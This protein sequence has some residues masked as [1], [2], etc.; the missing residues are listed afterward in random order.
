M[1]IGNWYPLKRQGEVGSLR[2]AS[3][4]LCLNIKNNEFF[5]K[6]ADF[7]NSGRTIPFPL[8]EFVF[9]SLFE[10][11]NLYATIPLPGEVRA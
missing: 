3:V 10:R 1:D 8:P 7:Q 2:N 5:A 9:G 11:W 6:I 4:N